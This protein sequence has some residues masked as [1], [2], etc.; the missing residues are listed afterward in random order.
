MSIE[1]RTFRSL[2][3]EVLEHQFSEAKYRPLVKTWLNEAQRRAVIESEMRIEETS[4]TYATTAGDATYA[5]PSN[6]NRLID[7]FNTETNETLTPVDIREFDQL[8]ASQGKPYAYTVIGSELNLYAT[9]DGEY[10]LKLRYW[11]LPADM[12]EDNSTPEIPVQYQE[13]LIA[14]AMKKAFMREDDFQAAQMWDTI[15]KEG[16]LK[17]RGEVQHDVFEGPRQV[18][19]SWSSQGGALSNSWWR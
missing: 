14:Y 15:W 1:G 9:P 11:K 18:E 17:M 8:P 5:L 13:L 7:V 10:P 6:F 12:V 4:E 2:Q 16:I 3:D 19:G